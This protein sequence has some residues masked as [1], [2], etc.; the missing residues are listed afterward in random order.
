MGPKGQHLPQLDSL[1]TFAVFAVMVGHLAS[2]ATRS[3]PLGDLGVR[4]FFV[5]SGFLIT[6][7]L[8]EC[9]RLVADG[10][11][12]SSVIGRFY[13]RRFLRIAPLFY[14]VLAVMWFLAMPE[15][16]DS[17]AWHLPYASNI[18]F[19]RLG[20]WHGVTS[21]LWSLAVEEQFYLLWP[22]VVLFLP[23]RWMTALLL[24]VAVSAPLF[25]L[26]GMWR[27]WSLIS[28][29]VLPFASADSLALGALLASLS[30]GDAR[31]RLRLTTAGLWLGPLALA[32]HASTAFHV[33]AGATFRAAIVDT[34]WSAWFVWLIDRA[35]TGFRGAVGTVLES[36]PLVYL[37]RISYGLYLINPLS[38]PVGRWLW[39]LAGFGGPYP[40]NALVG[41]GAPI[42][43]TIVLAS[44]SWLLYERPINRLNRYVPYDPRP[45]LG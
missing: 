40:P 20:E 38:P 5:L 16:R 4:L 13:V 41:V 42:A 32:I 26:V 44:V 22:M 7:I 14:G 6:R 1:R 15:I 34:L 36:R 30:T 10:R 3:L 27:G 8:L 19:A 21:H 45:E 37:G 18:Y 2:R 11:S 35:A 12:P 31:G 43:V 9:R 24:I 29:Y 28:I 25:R 23:A 33:T 39:N 17:L